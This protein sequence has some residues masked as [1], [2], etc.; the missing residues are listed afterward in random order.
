MNI[1][2]TDQQRRLARE[3][4]PIDVVDTET[5]EAYIL[6]AKQKYENTVPPSLPSASSVPEGI[7]LSQDAL[8]RDLPQLLHDKRLV[9][10]WVAYHRSER[11]GFGR[12][13][14]SLI[15]ECLKR[16]LSDD[17]FYVGWV[18]PCELIEEEEIEPRPQHYA[19]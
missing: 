1:E 8:R 13:Q 16:G 11:I 4:Q 6:I 7:R 9:G 12:D 17:D 3:G 19:E 2:L 15:C 14:A 5:N 10:Q 18:N